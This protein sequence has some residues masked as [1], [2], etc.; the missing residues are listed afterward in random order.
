MNGSWLTYRTKGNASSDT[1]VRGDGREPLAPSAV[2]T[3]SQ[4]QWG[5]HCPQ[6]RSGGVVVGIVKCGPACE[7]LTCRIQ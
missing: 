6:R 3:T 1:R 7:L 5:A 4:H 2:T